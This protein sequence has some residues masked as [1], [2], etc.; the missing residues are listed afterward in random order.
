VRV[1]QHRHEDK[2]VPQKHGE[3]GLAASSSPPAIMPLASMYVGMLTL[4]AIHK[5][6]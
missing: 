4:I 5:A 2:D 3:N 6:A 1:E